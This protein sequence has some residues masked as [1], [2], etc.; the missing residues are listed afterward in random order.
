[1]SPSSPDLVCPWQW[2]KGTGPGLLW[3]CHLMKTSIN[4]CTLQLAIWLCLLDCSPPYRSPHTERPVLNQL[5]IHFPPCRNTPNL[6][7]LL[8]GCW[9][10]MAHISGLK[11]FSTWNKHGVLS[12]CS[13]LWVPF[14]GILRAPMEYD[15]PTTRSSRLWINKNFLPMCDLAKLV[16]C[17]HL[18]FL[19][20]KM[21]WPWDLNYQNRLVLSIKQINICQEFR[22]VPGP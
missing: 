11:H 10:L 12:F 2:L 3:I 1:M 7:S 14:M 13:F 4:M 20:C 5:F 9:G 16:N 19:T 18:G 6:R 17:V 21:R 8:Q 15:T 22:W